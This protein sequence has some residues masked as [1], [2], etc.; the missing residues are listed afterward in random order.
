MKANP[1]SYM[2]KHL[3][4]NTQQQVQ[5]LVKNGILTRLEKEEHNRDNLLGIQ[6]AL[7]AAKTSINKGIVHPEIIEKIEERLFTNTDLHQSSRFDYTDFL[8]YLHSKGVYNNF[9]PETLDIITGKKSNL[10]GAK[11]LVA[12]PAVSPQVVM[13]TAMLVD[14]KPIKPID[15]TEVWELDKV[16]I[17]IQNLNNTNHDIV[18]LTQKGGA[19]DACY[20][21]VRNIAKK[22]SIVFQQGEYIHNWTRE[23][24]AAWSEKILK[25]PEVAN[26]YKMLPEMLAVIKRALLLHNRNTP[27]IVQL[28]SV[29]MMALS[30]NKGKLLQIS[31]GEGKSCTTAM[32]AVLNGLK[33]KNVD[34]ITSS[35]V[36]ARR[37]AEEWSSFY[38]IFGLT[39]GHNITIG[40]VIGLKEC[41]TKNIVYGDALHYQADTLRDEYKLLGTKGGRNFANSVALIDEVDSMLIDDS[42]RIA[43]LATPAPS[44]EYLAP[45]FLTSF[46]Y[47][48]Q[49]VNYFKAEESNGGSSLDSQMP[50]IEKNITSYIEKL[51]GVSDIIDDTEQILVPKHLQSFVERQAPVWAKSAIQALSTSEKR[52]Y[53]I[54][55]Q[56]GKKV[57]API[58]Y[59]STGVV[60]ERT[61]WTNG[62]HQYMQIKHNLAMSSENLT[63]SFISNMEYFKR[64]NGQI[65][66]MSGTLGSIHE[67]ELLKHVYDIDLAFI[68]TFKPKQFTELPAIVAGSNKE[69][70]QALLDTTK[71]VGQEK[72]A[73][74][75]LA[76]TIEDVENIQKSL[77]E[78]GIDQDLIHKYT[79]GS[80]EENQQVIEEK[81]R[82]GHVIVATN[83]AGRGTDIKVTNM[84]ENAGGLH[85]CVSFLPTNLRVEEQAFGRTARQ[86]MRGSAQLIV[87]GTYEALKLHKAVSD[88]ENI[89]DLS[90]INALKLRRDAAELLRLDDIQTRL[91]PKISIEDELFARFSALSHELKSR[92]NNENKLRQLE[93]HWGLWF[94]D[95]SHKL[96]AENGINREEILQSL[97]SFSE[98]MKARYGSN[99]IMQNPAYLTLE[100]VNKF[101]EGNRYDH[102]IE[103]LNHVSSTAEEYGFAANYNLAYCYFRQNSANVRKNDMNLVNNGIEHLN[104]SLMQLETVAIPQ[105]HMMQIM[106][107]SE[108]NNSELATQ[109]ATKLNLH[110]MQ[111]NYIRNAL[112]KIEQGVNQGKVIVVKNSDSKPIFEIVGQSPNN[113]SEEVLELACFGSTQFFTLDVK[114][115]PRDILSAVGVGIIG[116][117]QFIVG[118]LVTVC[119]AGSATSL[120]VSMMMS[121]AQDLYKGVRVGMGKEAMDWGNYWINKGISYAVSII[122]MGWDNFKAG[123]S[124][125]KEQAGR[126][127]DAGKNFFTGNATNVMGR[128]AASQ[129]AKEGIKEGVKDTAT[130][131]TFTS[132]AKEFIA[133]K[134]MSVVVMEVSKSIIAQNVTSL[135]AKE[136][137]N[138]LE[139]TQEDVRSDAYDKIMHT[140]NSEPTSMHLNRLIAMDKMIGNQSH[141]QA[142]KAAATKALS[143]KIDRITQLARQ[144]STAAMSGMAARSGNM[145]ANVG[146]KVA[147]TGAGILEATNEIKHLIGDF[148]DD[149]QERIAEINQKAT[150]LMPK[151]MSAYMGKFI[152][153]KED[154]DAIIAILKQNQVL[155]TDTMQF[156][157]ELMKPLVNFEAGIA[158]QDPLPMPVI[159]EPELRD[160]IVINKRVHGE[161]QAF[162]LEDLRKKSEYD[163]AKNIEEIDFGPFRYHRDKII[164]VARHLNDSQVKDHQ[165][166]KQEL[167]EELAGKVSNRTIGIIRHSI[168]TPVISPVVNIGVD[169]MAQ[170]FMSIATR[171]MISGIAAGDEYLERKM[172][173]YKA[174]DAVLVDDRGEEDFSDDDMPSLQ[175]KEDVSNSAPTQKSKSLFARR[176]NSAL[177]E[178]IY[179]TFD[180]FGE[181]YNKSLQKSTRQ[182]NV[183]SLDLIK[184]R[185]NEINQNVM[186]IRRG[187]G[188]AVFKN[189]SEFN[190]T[191]GGSLRYLFDQASH[192]SHLVSPQVTG[193]INATTGIIGHGISE[194]YELSLPDSAKQYIAETYN[195]RMGEFP[196]E[197][198]RFLV[199]TTMGALVGQVT[200]KGLNLAIINKANNPRATSALSSSAPMLENGIKP[201][202]IT[203]SGQFSSQ[204]THRA[205]KEVLG[206][207]AIIKGSARELAALEIKTI[208]QQ[209][210]KSMA[211]VGHKRSIDDIN[212]LTDTYGGKKE[213]WVKKTTINLNQRS[214]VNK[215]QKVELHWYENLKNGVKVEPKIKK[216]D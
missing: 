156:N 128:Q 42:G 41:Y 36:L 122:S 71:A 169:K 4:S 155:N 162:Q 95:T 21:N 146:M 213:D 56:D 101:G 60:Q 190:E 17:D 131:T 2:G 194:L 142:V 50:W 87:N 75:I 31:T 108:G 126:L 172:K 195:N 192:T 141:T 121:G 124:A 79:T 176:N 82:V 152:R 22:D 148:C 45:I 188:H 16:L 120:G 119:S 49:L 216:V 103:L 111:S 112:N 48:K 159:K 72:R 132:I 174:K 133:K 181:R 70:H 102:S 130:Q 206:D 3:S 158:F 68:P 91:I 73:T 214:L 105:L 137:A 171:P 107:G 20:R 114:K 25:H 117:S 78:G 135:V 186:A 215:T 40:Q 168:I 53:L 46:N 89:A 57:I 55:G 160:G 116:V 100:A 127:V 106:I 104:Q 207:Q 129:I 59:A 144:L 67:Q 34:V 204:I 118:A 182:Q 139:G 88:K 6:S 24:I 210:G 208:L 161:V 15:F 29:I 47:L 65:F 123:L 151:V 44:M 165:I 77:I 154:I 97:E 10:L 212:R 157:N 35:S 1:L 92:E 18:E 145:V 179:K 80:A 163:G 51:V 43:K 200:A 136:I 197:N 14:T 185:N 58:D 7:R 187:N 183:S 205:V 143:P 83:L 178:F 201:M 61:S 113:A 164:Q 170:Q 99:A 32:L 38:D 66:G 173:V 209:D 193:A 11:T 175:Q 63:S 37:D 13:Q 86:G 94:K 27:R 5:E 153:Q 125:V 115:P 23:N 189:A 81:A 199:Q 76:E 177:D 203:H 211:G 140:L 39:N 69:W 150:D 62:L 52:D 64:Y 54:I 147:I 149:L 109:V 8:K 12:I 30:S 98:D 84:V 110:K 167:A 180:V 138:S 198:Q 28:A 166:E 90:D 191:F 134:G 196:T 184:E 9:K 202:Q 33:S 93:E 74:L 19:L 96:E 85:V 26:D